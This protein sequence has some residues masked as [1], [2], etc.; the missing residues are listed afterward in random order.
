VDTHSEVRSQD[1]HD[2]SAELREAE[3][4]LLEGHPTG[5]FGIACKLFPEGGL[6]FSDL[7][8]SA[9]SYLLAAEGRIE[10]TMAA[11]NAVS[12]A[13]DR[14]QIA[15]QAT[16]DIL[17]DCLNQIASNCVVVCKV[18]DIEGPHQLRIV[19][20]R[21]RSVFAVDEA[22]LESPEMGRL[23]EETKWLGHEVRRLRDL[24]VVANDVVGQEAALHLDESGLSA[25]AETLVRKAG[26]YRNHVR[27]ILTDV[28]AQA[29]L[30]DL[31]QFDGAG[32]FPPISR[33]RG[34]WRYRSSMWRSRDSPNAGRSARRLRASKR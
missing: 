21:L 24:D 10:P 19:L 32:S 13:V 14:D 2:C 17:R 34:G 20:R 18:D 30:I 29:F 28:R 7:S 31:A 4:E 5:L 25:L 23:S 11:R 8:N 6:Q 26:E 33:R 9:R 12:I 1:R 15:E 16:R 27:T 22:A 3:I